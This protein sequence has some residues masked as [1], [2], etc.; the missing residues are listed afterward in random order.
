MAQIDRDDLMALLEKV[1]S[2]LERRISLVAVGGTA[3]TLIGGKEAT[4][5]IDFDL[6]VEDAKLFRSALSKIPHGFRI[7]IFTGG[8][9]FSQQLPG[10]YVGRAKEIKT[11]L[12]NIRLLALSPADIIASKIGRLNERDLQDIESCVRKFKVSREEVKRIADAVEYV[13]HE[14]VYESSKEYVLRDFFK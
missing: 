2:L 7:D 11:R 4:I 13:G 1:D 5:D 6:S 14:E 12:K 9:I 3:L 8:L 10:D